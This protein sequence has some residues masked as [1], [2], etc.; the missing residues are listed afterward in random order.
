M[1]TLAERESRAVNQLMVSLLPVALALLLGLL[2]QASGQVC[3]GNDLSYYCP[4]FDGLNC[5]AAEA[6][7][8]LSR[9]ATSSQFC[10][11]TSLNECPFPTLDSMYAQCTRFCGEGGTDVPIPVIIGGEGFGL[12]LE[13][14]SKICLDETLLG[15]RYTRQAYDDCEGGKAALQAINDVTASFLAEMRVFAYSAI[16]Y[17]ADMATQIEAIKERLRDP[18]T[19]RAIASASTSAKPTVI[20]NI[21]REMLQAQGGGRTI[22]QQAISNV[23]QSATN[24]QVPPSRIFTR[25]SATSHGARPPHAALGHPIHMAPPHPVAPAHLFKRR[26]PNSFAHASPSA[27]CLRVRAVHMLIIRDIQVVLDSHI[28]RFE[29]FTQN[30]NTFFPKVSTFLLDMCTKTGNACI[31]AEEYAATASPLH[32]PLG[33]PPDLQLIWPM[34]AMPP[35]VSVAE[36]STSRAAVSTTRSRAW[37]A[38]DSSRPRPPRPSR[39]RHPSRR[40]RLPRPPPDRADLTRRPRRARNPL[41]RQP[42]RPTTALQRPSPKRRCV[43]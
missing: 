11:E 25:R 5:T 28:T 14:A 39:P 7:L 22:I 40:V 41:T 16:S 6:N 24:M 36:R 12:D 27:H 32:H 33:L 3:L 19:I 13:S 35:G 23:R 17:Q 21:Y 37:R 9:S 42:P 10:C 4:N 38:R 30:C 34:R 2:Q 43:S 15:Q 31:E 26:R 1:T 20:Q 18:E 29:D 8:A